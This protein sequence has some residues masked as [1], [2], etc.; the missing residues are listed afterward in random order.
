VVQRPSFAELADEPEAKLDVVALALAAEFRDVDAAGALATLDVLGTEL[1]SAA[2]QTDGTPAALTGACAQVLGAG[3]RFVGERAQYDHPDNSMLDLVL[4]RRRGLPIALSVVYVEVARR[5]GIELDGV[6]LPGH[7]VVG[8]FGAQP[9]L[10][11]DPFAGGGPLSAEFSREPVR[12]WGV[13]E[14]AMRM[15]NNLVAAYHRRGDL[16][17]AIHAAALRTALPAQADEREL[18]ESQ[19]RAI[20]ARLN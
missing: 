7:F 11:L 9:P 5:A 10:L 19:L 18:L 20:Q 4:K 15:L 8:H 14:I 13:H 17:A 2:Q 12:P 16:G 3:H 1:S 6:G